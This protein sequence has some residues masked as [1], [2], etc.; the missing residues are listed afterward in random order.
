VVAESN[1]VRLFFSHGS[2]ALHL[3][4]VFLYYLQI[5]RVHRVELGRL[6]TV[7]TAGAQDGE[8]PLTVSFDCAASRPV[9]AAAV[10]PHLFASLRGVL[11]GLVASFGASSAIRTARLLRG[12]FILG[13][14]PR[15]PP[16]ILGRKK[17]RKHSVAPASNSRQTCSAKAQCMAPLLR[18]AAW[19]LAAVGLVQ[20]ADL[21]PSENG[22]FGR[23]RFYLDTDR[24]GQITANVAVCLSKRESAAG[25]QPWSES[26]PF[27]TLTLE[28]LALVQCNVLH[29]G[30]NR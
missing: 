8:H 25:E 5:V 21:T 14:L 11:R 7:S 24:D 10:D 9:H 4:G 27:P 17:V 2:Q 19:L 1:Q 20:A 16:R 6:F 3:V 29:S 28:T 13:L 23:G 12:S 15:L 18:S 26:P 22:Q 30:H